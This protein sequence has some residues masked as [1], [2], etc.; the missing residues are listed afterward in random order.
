MLR[1]SD[2][3]PGH[4]QALPGPLARVMRHANVARA[5]RA[6]TSEF[7]GRTLDVHYQL[8]KVG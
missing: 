3:G 2:L 7:G 6:S 5:Q 4:T 8:V 1:H